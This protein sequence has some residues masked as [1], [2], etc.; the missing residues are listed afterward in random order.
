MLPVLDKWLEDEGIS[1]E[2][3]FQIGIFLLSVLTRKCYEIYFV[4]NV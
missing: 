3:V 2:R 1:E 4:V